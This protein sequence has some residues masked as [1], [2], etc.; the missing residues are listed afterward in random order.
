LRRPRQAIYSRY[1]DANPVAAAAR[2]KGEG[3]PNDHGLRCAL[4]MLAGERRD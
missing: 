3:V 2:P 1:C 4:W